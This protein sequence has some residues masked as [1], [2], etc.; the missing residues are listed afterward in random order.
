MDFNEFKADFEASMSSDKK[1]VK[2][3]ANDSGLGNQGL[4]IK[5]IDICKKCGLSR[6]KKYL[7]QC[8]C[9][10]KSHNDRAKQ[11]VLIGISSK[12]TCYMQHF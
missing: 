6:N 5:R 1:E 3:S 11:V 7:K 12:N 8:E 9:C 10:T 4:L 2:L